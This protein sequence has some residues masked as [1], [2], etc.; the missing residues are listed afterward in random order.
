MKRWCFCAVFLLCVACAAPRMQ[1]Q[2]SVIQAPELASHALISGDD[3]ALPL[4]KWLPHG[5]PKAIIVALHGFNDY[6]KGFA[7]PAQYLKHYGIAVYAYDQRGFGRAPNP[8]IWPGEDNLVRDAAN[9]VAVV[10]KRYPHTPLY[11]MGE[12]M[13]G[14]VAIAALSRP[15]FPTVD[16]LIL[17]A[18][19]VWGG[20]SMSPLWRASLWVAV[21]VWPGK[22]LT[23]ED[24][25]VL[26]SDN[27]AM[28]R[29]LSRDPLVIKKTRVD[30][31]YGLVH[32]MDTAY[33]RIG[34]VEVPV[35]FLYGAR[36]QV[37]PSEPIADALCK[38][39][40][41]V[42]AAYYPMGYHMLLRDLH[43]NKPLQDIVSWI[44]NQTRPLPSGYSVEAE[45]LAEALRKHKSDMW[46]H[47]GMRPAS[48]EVN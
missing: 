39:S 18:P 4:Q 15:G 2:F 24:L 27:L 37:I 12:S 48:S 41:Q 26:A 14:A 11:V 32:L 44:S 47:A 13:G 17:S 35:F 36:D 31:I 40:G 43:R 29:A 19:A 16:G 45:A 22:R 30:A 8:G 42:T 28:L 34:S 7:I 10:K 46:A 6:S 23:G 25:H 33:S 5:R 3:A 9:M 1:P 38:V 21:H 20:E